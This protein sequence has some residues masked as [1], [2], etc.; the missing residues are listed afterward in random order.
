MRSAARR[1]ELQ[2]LRCRETVVDD[3]V[4]AS[5]R[6]GALDG[7]QVGVARTGAHERD[8]A[9][10][11]GTSCSSR[12]AQARRELVAAAGP[13]ETDG[14]V[15]VEGG[16][17]P[18]GPRATGR[19]AMRASRPGPFAAP[20]APRPTPRRTADESCARNFFDS[21]GDA[22]P[23]AIATTSSPRRTTPGADQSQFGMS[24][25]TFTSAC[26]RRASRA[27]AVRSAGSG[28]DATTRNA[29]SRSSGRHPRR[30]TA[31]PSHER[32]L[33][34]TIRRPRRHDHDVV[35]AGGDEPLDLALRTASSPI[36]TQRR[37]ASS[38]ITG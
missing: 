3:D 16:R 19:E 6:L 23:V 27:I 4:G 36:T 9:G 28:L 35:G 38:S 26:R 25:M 14:L 29:P 21:A 24:S 7:D 32:E 20:R 5:Q 12:V 22:P 8:P 30:R 11:D 1:C 13:N 15:G 10:H 18:L 31:T 17:P 34:E 37:P 2:Q 33:V